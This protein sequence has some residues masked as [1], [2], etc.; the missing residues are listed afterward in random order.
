MKKKTTKITKVEVNKGEV[1]ELKFDTSLLNKVE[2][3]LEELDIEQFNNDNIDRNYIYPP[4]YL[5]ELPS[6]EL[7]RYLHTIIQ[8]RVWVRTC[9]A[10]VSV[11]LNDL[12]DKLDAEKMR[13]YKEFELPP[14]MAVGEKELYLFED[15]KAKK[16][17][18]QIR[19]TEEKKNMLNSYM[20]NLEDYKFD[21]SREVSRRE[22]DFSGENRLYNIQQKKKGDFKRREFQLK[23]K[24]GS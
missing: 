1:D 16:L 18:E 4:A 8:Q 20:E 7:G 17:L 3:E 2:N 15:K 14:R 23:K 11:I 5:D 12:Y 9:L 19:L 6:N 10:R 13:V 21:I 22:Q 24:G